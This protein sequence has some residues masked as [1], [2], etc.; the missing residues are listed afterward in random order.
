MLVGLFI[1]LLPDVSVLV[2]GAPVDTHPSELII[3]IFEI[4][5]D[6]LVAPIIPKPAVDELFVV[7]SVIIRLNE[8]IQK[9]SKKLI[10]KIFEFFA[11][12]VESEVVV[13]RSEVM[14]DL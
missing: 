4:L 11:D 10:L 8:K 12:F 9:N 3:H 2:S 14:H 5:G 6:G 13:V 1:R 7:S